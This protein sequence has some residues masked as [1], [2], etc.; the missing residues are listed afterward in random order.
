MISEE[1]LQK[2]LT[3][4]ANT[5]EPYAKARAYLDA[6]KVREKTVLATSYLNISGGTVAEKDHKA[7]ESKAYEEWQKNYE[8]AVYDHEIMRNKRS[9]EALIVEVWRTESANQRR[10]NI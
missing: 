10:G 9:T 3:Y 1:R 5:D 8:D 6:M 2:A 4:L 7:R